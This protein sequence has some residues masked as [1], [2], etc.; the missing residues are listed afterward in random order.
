M[1]TRAAS[2]TAT[3]RDDNVVLGDFG[4][5]IV[6]DW[7]F[8][9]MFP[10]ANGRRQ[11]AGEDEDQPADAGRSPKIDAGSAAG[12][13]AGREMHWALPRTCLPNRRKDA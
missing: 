7:G 3:S 13:D 10:S 9:K 12:S 6:L 5:V 8:A 11:P 1:L 4:E 2:S